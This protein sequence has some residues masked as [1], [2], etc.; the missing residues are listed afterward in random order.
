MKSA[1][2]GGVAPFDDADNAAHAASIGLGR[3]Y[4]NQHLIALHGAVDLVRGD[5]NVFFHPADEDLSAGTPVLSR[6]LPRIGPDEAVAVAMQIEPPCGQIL[7]RA[8]DGPGNAPV[9]AVKLDQ[10]ASCGQT[11]QLYQQQT[12]FASA[13]QVQLANQ[14]FVSGFLSGGASNPRHQFRICHR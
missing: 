11:G 7:A 1:D 14:L 6:S 10:R 9:L 8:E 2:Y 12:P 3:L 4:F 13:A 5:K